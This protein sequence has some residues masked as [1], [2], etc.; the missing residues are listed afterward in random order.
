MPLNQSVA[1][2]VRFLA[3]RDSRFKTASLT[4]ALLLP[5]RE[6]TASAYALLPYL[7]R[8]G[9]AAYPDY[10]ALQQRLNELYGAS[11]NASVA[12]IGEMQ[13]LMLSAV[14]IDDR[15]ALNKE[16]VA[17][18]CAELLLSMLFEPVLEN[19]VFRT[20]DVEQERRCLLERIQSEINEKRLYAR[21]RCEQLL[22]AGEPYAVDRYGTPERV[23]ALDEAAVTA[24]WK[25]ALR[26]ARIQLIYQGEGDE[27]AVK[28]AFTASCAHIDGRNPCVAETLVR[29]AHEPV[30]EQTETMA[31]Q[32]AKLVMG[33]RT[34]V[35]EPSPEVDALRLMNA[36]LGG[37]PHS[38]LFRNVR[39]RLSLCY[40]CAS[41][42]DRQKGVLL[43]DSG[44][45]EE[46]AEQ[47]KAE[48]LRQLDAIRAGN[49]TAE[50]LESA[51]LSVINQ[52]RT[53]GDLQSTLAGW[54]LGQCA[55]ETLR[56]PEQ[57]AQAIEAVTRE[58]VMHAAA[59]VALEAVY[60]LAPEKGG[61]SA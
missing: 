22:C 43:V 6:E 30:R 39:E 48:I 49:F 29:A 5:L 41:S 32:Q 51:R 7:L 25:Q 38:L 55:G 18:Q 46:K 47:A 4:V 15:F 37:T 19:G 14:S 3:L 9:C 1:E 59:Q 40:Y 23:A 11:I 27:Q 24:A 60:R 16:A 50:D 35:A 20:A 31:V 10:T 26:E 58:Q 17:A 13:T 45:E 12:R 8:R 33:F 56:T 2:G 28:A 53:V 44:V 36:L 42:Y 54:Y 21:S 57:A 52:F 61:E 34:A